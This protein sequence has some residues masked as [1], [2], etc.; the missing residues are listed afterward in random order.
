ME[1][2]AREPNVHVKLSE[3]GLPGQAWDWHANARVVRDTV[4]IFGWQRCMFASNFPVASLRIGY[5]ELVDGVLRMLGGLSPYER[6]AVMCGNALRF[7]RV[8]IPAGAS[9]QPAGDG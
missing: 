9:V 1:T 5:R 8:D 6:H 4:A 7:Y 3:F 2:L